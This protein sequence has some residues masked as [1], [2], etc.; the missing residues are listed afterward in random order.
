M[1]SRS[2]T[3]AG[4]LKAKLDNPRGFF[5]SERLVETNDQ[6]LRMISCSWD[7]PPLLTPIWGSKEFMDVF[8][9]WREE[10]HD[11]AL[12]KDWIDKDPRLCITY[13]AYLH[14]L[15][16]RIPILGVVRKPLEVATSLY[17]RNGLPIDSGLSIWY[18][19][20]HHLASSF[21]QEDGLFFY[22]DLLDL[23]NPNKAT[24]TYRYLTNFFER[25]GYRILARRPGTK[26][27]QEDY[28]LV[29]IGHLNLYLL[30]LL[31]A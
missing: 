30:I 6:L 21:H 18:L 9:S 2:S 4:D 25:Y 20:N 8:E 28:P 12:T 16:K 23:N 14:I 13:N 3:G 22:E 15:L 19:Y 11:Y 26:R 1:E 17:A 10:F 24:I 27:F 29:L 31:I 5:E 7:H